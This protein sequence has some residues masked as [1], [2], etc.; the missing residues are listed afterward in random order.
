M[1]TDDKLLIIIDQHA[2]DERIRLDQFTI[3]YLIIKV[4]LFNYQATQIIK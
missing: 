1:H 3:G 2:A 4:I